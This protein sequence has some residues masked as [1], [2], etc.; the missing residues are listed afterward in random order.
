MAGSLP[1]LTKVRPPSRRADALRR[2]RLL[3]GLFENFERKLLLV[4]APAGY[5]KTT[6]LTDLAHE[7]PVPVAWL[8]LDPADRDPASFIEYL[9]R[10]L[11]QV[12][13]DFGATILGALRA[14][15][16]IEGRSAELA[17]T[18]AADVHTNIR[19]VCM[20]VLDDFHEV[21]D[22]T[23]VTNFL[24]ELLRILPE[25][26]RI[27]VAGRTLVNLTVSRLAVEGELFGVG[28]S[29]LRFAPEEVAS[30]LRQRY[31]VEPDR[32]Q[33]DA[34]IEKTEGWIA[35]LLL[36]IHGL[37]GA[38][39]SLA[40][41]GISGP[42]PLYTY[43]ADE[44]YDR[45]SPE[46]RQFL[47]ATSTMRT[48][49]PES[50]TALLGPGNWLEHLAQAERTNLFVA[51]LGDGPPAYRYHQLFREF[52]QGRLRSEQ[53]EQFETLHLR[54]A[55]YLADAH[56]WPGAIEHFH[57]AHAY[58]E[59]A[60]L[61]THIAPQLE[62]DGR[63]YLLARTIDELPQEL[64][65][66]SGRLQLARARAA[67]L[68]GDLKGAEVFARQAI[69]LS[70][71]QHAPHDQAWSLQVLGNAVRRLG[72]TQEAF[73]A[74]Q[75]ARTLAPEDEELVASIRRD[76][77]GCYGVQGD[78]QAAA[79]EYA[80]ARDYFVRCSNTYEAARAAYGVGAA[81]ARMGRAD[82]ACEHYAEALARWREAGDP[83]NI[84]L[85]LNNMGYIRSFQG[86]FDVARTLLEEGLEHANLAGHRFAQA[87]LHDSLGSLLLN[88]G[89]LPAAARA[90]RTGMEIAQDAG[91]LWTATATMEGTGLCA[92]FEGDTEA[93]TEWFERAIALA[94]R[95]QSAYRRA[96]MTVDRGVV[97]LQSGE[98]GAALATLTS[99]E[100]E[101]SRLQAQRDL[102]RARVW[103]AHA[104]Y[105]RGDPVSAGAY[106]QAAA[107]EAVALN[108]PALLDL[109]A[110][111]DAD[112]FARFPAGPFQH[113]QAAVL[114]RLGEAPYPAHV[115]PAS[116]PATPRY[117][118]S[119]FGRARV[120]NEHGEAVE[121]GRE[122]SRELF[123]YLLHTGAARSSRVAAD[124]WPDV[125]PA[126]AKP[127]VYSAVY[128]LRQ[129]THPEALQA[130]ERTYSLQPD[131]V[132]YHDVDEFDRI[133]AE[134]RSERD[135][136]RRLALMEELV[137]L[138]TG[139]LLDDVD[140]E[141]ATESRRAYELRYL[142]TL[143]SLVTAYAHRGRWDTCLKRALEGIQIDPECDAF[144]ENAAQAYR[145]LGKPW[146]ARRLARRRL[147]LL[148][149]QA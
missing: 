60:R 52:L 130:V 6:L 103:I 138:H 15:G 106:F 40:R 14:A 23:A 145:S 29:D 107:E 147:S 9:V 101:L 131:V 136:E 17:R 133:Y 111:W 127:L 68:T 66:R 41:L 123:F 102:V 63:W 124:L 8:T 92:L 84:A 58:D 36:S 22:S 64:R 104:H 43:L 34:L 25:N 50:C 24:D 129:A 7:S 100:A 19:G 86:D 78:F 110:R 89:D 125:S 32:R 51:R 5:G 31:G 16:D 148:D 77:A 99:A 80:A 1:L 28:L 55:R 128:A 35:G 88:R 139:P 53:P 117:R 26:L 119:S 108:V 115:S 83:G 62:R 149:Q 3:D 146:S 140:A 33:L 81:L 46:L 76:L 126:R 142:D 97:L 38:V 37:D 87:C 54:A 105:R 72:R 113:I 71:E 4:L 132:A 20:L 98:V 69:G 44:A 30:L 120:L 42:A 79:R 109:P 82:E 45:Q 135:E 141:W 96:Q 93:A 10:A 144:Y 114:K 11:Q 61:I 13:P 39:D 57:E 59:A 95:Q 143:E 134:I 21:N 85:V 74:L 75:R 2:Q 121:W 91:D 56:D 49:T 65:T 73:E 112:A 12:A 47:L 70:I 48:L 137:S 27:V 118:V 18:L 90:F 94:D 67:V 116:V 122:K